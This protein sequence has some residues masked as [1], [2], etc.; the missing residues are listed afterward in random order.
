MKETEDEKGYQGWTNYETWVTKLWM[1]NDEGTHEFFRDLT[2]QARELAPTSS[3]VKKGVW[4]AKEAERFLLAD[5]VKEEIEIMVKGE[6]DQA[7]LVNDLL[8]AS[9]SDIN[10]VEIAVSLLSD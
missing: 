3:Q 4:T 2:I 10:F 6:E 7:G 5:M 1:D 8:N 9:I